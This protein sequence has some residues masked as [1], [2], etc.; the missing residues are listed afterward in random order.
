MPLKNLSVLSR[1]HRSRMFVEVRSDTTSKNY[2]SYDIRS[3]PTQGCS[4]KRMDRRARGEYIVDEQYRLTLKAYISLE[5]TLIRPAMAYIFIGYPVQKLTCIPQS[6]SFEYR[7]KWVW[8]CTP[9]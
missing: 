2:S 3:S 1:P 8:R 5:C 9:A 6:Y 7:Q 4:S